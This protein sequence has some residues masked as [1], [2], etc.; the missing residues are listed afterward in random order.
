MVLEESS[1]FKLLGQSGES[2]LISMTDAASMLQA[3]S[4]AGIAGRGLPWAAWWAS[5]SG[6]G[7]TRRCVTRTGAGLWS[8]VAMMIVAHPLAGTERAIMTGT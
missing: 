7:T 6:V 5:I 1:L 3:M 8:S 2:S 4:R